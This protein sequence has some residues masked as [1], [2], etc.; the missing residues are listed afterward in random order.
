MAAAVPVT[1]PVRDSV[2]D[3]SLA[4]APVD[5]DTI[6]RSASYREAP[7]SRGTVANPLNS[8]GRKTEFLFNQGTASKIRWGGMA[9]RLTMEISAA[10]AAMAITGNGEPKQAPDWNMV[11]RLIRQIK[12]ELNTGKELYSSSDGH[13]LEEFTANLLRNHTWQELSEN[14][15]MLFTPLGDTT[16]NIRDPAAVAGAAND[17][18]WT[19][20][21]LKYCNIDTHLKPIT[22]IIPFLDLFPRMPDAVF[23]NLHTMKITITW[24][25]NTDLLTTTGND[26]TGLVYL[27]KADLLEDFYTL[28]PTTAIVETEQKV[29]QQQPDIIPM[30]VP[31][32]RTF[33]YSQDMQITI[34]GVKNLESV[35]VFQFAGRQSNGAAAAELR[36]HDSYGQFKF[37]SNASATTAAG[38]LVSADAPT[39]AT[40]ANSEG[41]K[42]IGITY[43]GR[44]YPQQLMLCGQA[45]RGADFAQLYHEYLKALDRFGHPAASGAIP[46]EVFKTTMPFLWVR[47]FAPRAP[48]LTTNSD[49]IIQTTSG[50]VSTTADVPDLVVVYFQYQVAKLEAGGTISFA[51]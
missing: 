1:Q 34:P 19:A 49:L 18:A 36:T 51:V 10:G 21:G 29:E 20:R 11:G 15:L 13:Y 8:I 4:S 33:R 31:M 27:L 6:Y 2:Y 12:L 7:D 46:Y 48:K 3:R 39:D 23:R 16:Y 17:A 22:K 28:E 35:M 44:S 38:T 40:V 9:L 14:E 26:G 41:I 45:G 43:N 5:Q 30:V 47:P 50:T 37:V 25:G 24:N 32:V 42:S